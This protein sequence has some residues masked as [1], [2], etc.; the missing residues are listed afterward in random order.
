M[1][2]ISILGQTCSGKSVM[3][4]DLAKKLGDV[5][6]LN[7]DSRQVYKRLDIGT[8]KISGGWINGVF[9]CENVSHFLIDYV[10]PK[11]K[12][13][14]VDYVQDYIS[15]IQNSPNL[16]DY[17]ILTGG[18]GLYAKA[19]LDQYQFGIVKD[20]FAKEY[21][22]LKLSLQTKS[23][24]ELQTSLP[25]NDLDQSGYHNPPRLINSILQQ[26]AQ[27]NDWI[28]TLDY[29]QFEQIF[30]FAIRVDQTILK[31]RITDRIYERLEA[32]L[33]NE[34]ENLSDLGTM[35]VL[36]LG[37]EYRVTQLNLLGCFTREEYIDK[38]IQENWHYAKRQ[39]TWLK[40]Q[41]VVWIQNISDVLS[42]ITEN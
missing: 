25:N 40:R 10:N 14:I 19:I 31:Q 1:K 16:P 42:V 5:W 7:C 34:V 13:S 36:D 2:L 9:M 35:R 12:I 18:S 39:L 28:T 41:N 8:A 4:I 37:L 3:A 24:T 30:S 38:M 22:K 27:K 29:P 17:L 33:M 26:T 11:K 21:D 15:L 23:V 20:E 32:G 6:I